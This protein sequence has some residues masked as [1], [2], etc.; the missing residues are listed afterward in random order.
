MD[1]FVDVI[2]R[3]YLHKSCHAADSSHT[4]QGTMPYRDLISAV[5]F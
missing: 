3:T 4:W 5:Q 2:L 1:I